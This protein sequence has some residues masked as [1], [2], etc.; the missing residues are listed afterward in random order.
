MTAWERENGGRKEGKKKSKQE[1]PQSWYHMPGLPS[2][3]RQRSM[4]SFCSLTHTGGTPIMPKLTCSNKSHPPTS[5]TS[6]L[7]RLTHP[8]RPDRPDH[9][10]FAF[11]VRELCLI[12][13]EFHI[14]GV[15]QL[16]PDREKELGVRPRSALPSSPLSPSHPLSLSRTLC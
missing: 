12:S 14:D 9:H 5:P 3:M 4:Y 10:P 8:A 11:P 1:I 15:G 16:S 13:Q 7:T 6:C 2:L